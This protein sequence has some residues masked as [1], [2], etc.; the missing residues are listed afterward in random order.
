MAIDWTVIPARWPLVAAGGTLVALAIFLYALDPR[1]RI[2]RAVA[3]YLVVHALTLGLLGFETGG[4]V[5]GELSRVR[6]YTWIAEPFAAA[7]VVLAFISRFVIAGRPSMAQ[8]TRPAAGALLLGAVAFEVAYFL[9]HDAVLVS[10][11]EIGAFDILLFYVGPLIQAILAIVLAAAVLRVPAGPA[12]QG[13]FLGFAGFLMEAMYRVTFRIADDVFVWW[14]FGESFIEQYSNPVDVITLGIGFLLLLTLLALGAYLAYVFVRAAGGFR[15]S[16]EARILALGLAAF[17]SGWIAGYLEVSSPTIAGLDFT[18]QLAAVWL[19]VSL[20]LFVYAVLEYRFLTLDL[21]I[22][23]TLRAGVVAA[24]LLL[25]FYGVFRVAAFFVDGRVALLAGFVACAPIVLV[26]RPVW[27]FAAGLADV[28]MPHVS[29]GRD[30]VLRRKLELY[31]NALEEAAARGPGE[32][33]KDA[34]LRDLRRRLGIS[35]AEHR[36]MVLVA[37]SHERSDRR[38]RP[39]GREARFRVERELGRGTYGVAHLAYDTVLDRR[40]VLKQPTLPWIQGEEG[41]AMFV[42]EARLAAKLQHPNVVSVYEAFLEEDPPLLV[43]EYVPGSSLAELLREEGALGPKR[44]LAIALDVLSG[45]EAI[46]A[47]GIVHRDLKPANVLLTEDGQAKITDFGIAQPPPDSAATQT[48]AVGLAST[49]TLAYMSPEQARQEMADQRS[50][51]FSVGALLYE[52]LTGRHYLDLSAG[53]ESELRRRIQTVRP[54]FSAPQIT[55]S[56]VPIL[57]RALEKDPRRRYAHARELRRAL[58]VLSDR[59]AAAEASHARRLST[60]AARTA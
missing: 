56:F 46:H 8:W 57:S 9:D 23:A 4:R 35:E 12:R 26:R 6:Y 48:L 52:C 24:V 37:E 18:F 60:P 16:R 21:R 14:L 22:K 13:L 38:L 2:Y 33:E 47:R 43:L 7:N 54:D 42:R 50:D 5:G 58:S 17:A 10:S 30:Y 34:F 15:N 51:I 49:G 36:V 39:E 45:L 44:T 40:V 19:F 31:R 55:K 59:A 27:R 32:E 53:S 1:N 28:A 3:L 11:P 25:A 41:K 29:S 20:L